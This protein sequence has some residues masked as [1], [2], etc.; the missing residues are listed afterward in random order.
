MSWAA[1][2]KTSRI[3]DMA[4]C[5]MGILDINMPLLYGEGDKAFIR[6]QQDIAK[7]ST[8]ESLFAF[9]NNHVRRKLGYRCGL[10]AISPTYFSE[11]GNVKRGR[12]ISWIEHST[13]T[14]TDA[15]IQMEVSL[16][17]S[18]DNYWVLP[19]NCVTEKAHL[20]LVSETKS[21]RHA[22]H[23]LEYEGKHFR[24]VQSEGLDVMD[25]P[26]IEHVLERYEEMKASE[27]LKHQDAT[28]NLPPSV[29]SS[30]RTY[31]K[32]SMA[33]Y[34]RGMVCLDEPP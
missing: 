19:L 11:C 34:P 17:Q 24:T 30:R 33:F 28:A 8:D 4:Y 26:R 15:G 10:F 27:Q 20:S 12:Y 13:F 14:P 7:K 21:Q 16:I 18:S 32:P 1:G 2:R 5:L 9:N 29:H 3:E 31:I 22:V 25:D 23:L 6:L